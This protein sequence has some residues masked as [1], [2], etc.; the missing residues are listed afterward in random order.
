[1][2]V[3]GAVMRRV[4]AVVLLTVLLAA[5]GCSGVRRYP[6]QALGG[7]VL[8]L[9]VENKGYEPGTTAVFRKAAEERFLG[10]GA[11]LDSLAG[12]TVEITVTGA[13][14]RQMATKPGSDVAL[15][16]QVTVTGR[17]RV[18]AKDHD[19]PGKDRTMTQEFSR[20]YVYKVQDIVSG[21]ETRRDAFASCAADVADIVGAALVTLGERRP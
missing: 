16:Q 20:Q 4:Q 3:T 6:P 14:T 1:M 19:G 17:W 18:V 15:A 10:R 9:S 13:T 5:S 12:T 8:Q 2:N 11:R 21:E 7:M